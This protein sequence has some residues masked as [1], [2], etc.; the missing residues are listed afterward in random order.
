MHNWPTMPLGMCRVKAGALMAHV[1]EFEIVVHGEARTRRKPHASVDAVLV[2]V[3]RSCRRCSTIVSRTLPS[4]ANA[5]VS[6][7]M[8]RAGEAF[9]VLPDTAALGGA[10]FLPNR[11]P[12]RAPP[13][14]PPP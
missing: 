13:P 2:A 5:V 4:S 1:S 8:L 10:C 12:R 7:T 14:P 6:V 11:T 9:N 3:P